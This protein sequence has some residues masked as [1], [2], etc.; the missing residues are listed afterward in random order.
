MTRPK[1]AVFA[2]PNATILNT[3]PLVTSNLARREHQL[4]LRTNR[5][6][7]AARFDALR[8]QRLAA[9]VTV[10]IEQFSAHPL[11][12]DAAQLYAPPDGYLDSS[13]AFHEERESPSDKAVYRVTLGP[14]DGL[15]PLPYMARQASGQPWE[16][17]GV[18]PFAAP[19][20]NRQ[21][22]FPDASRLF[23]EIDR[24]AIGHDGLVN[25]LSSQA[26][27]DFYRCAPPG[28]YTCGLPAA[29]RTDMGQGEISEEIAGQDF[30]PYRPFHLLR[31][32]ARGSLA[33]AANL[34]QRVLDSGDYLAALWLEGSP[35]IEETVFWLGLTV[36]TDLPIVGCASQRP[37]GSI[38]NDGD[39]NIVDAVQYIV[40]RDWSD[41]AGMDRV[42]AVLVQDKRVYA[43]REAQKV[44]A[45]PGGYV[46]VGGAGGI[47]AIMGDPGPPTLLFV[48]TRRRGRTSEV[49]LRTLSDTTAG[50]RRST[51]GRV[52]TILVQVKEGP[53]RLMSSALPRVSIIKASHCQP[54]DCSGSADD[55]AGVLAEIERNLDV[56]P[57]AGFVGEGMAPYGF[58]NQ[59]LD[60]ALRRAVFSGMPV[61]NVGRGN[62]EGFA[63]TR[64]PFIAGSN[65][66]ATK[67]RLLLMACLLKFGALPAAT[68]PAQ[69]T[70]DEFSQTM[71]HVAGYQ[72]VFDS[73]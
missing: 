34:V 55:A 14:E 65:L 59:S 29:E 35:T 15:Y 6:G 1:I 54:D 51:T 58:M 32:P 17:D 47:V 20:L 44:D 52:E 27:F 24:F 50:V 2:G 43:A 62:T 70:G 28:G 8:P 68:D 53:D 72:S 64:P 46:A 5:D 26:E 42:G 56:A 41:A 49:R 31:Q 40:S 22:F 3:E 21:P 16:D 69:P 36:D 7:T 39:R 38:G 25:P 45:R 30:Y 61:V 73:H 9:P 12:R 19:E 18:Q 57:L 67:A 11:E 33:D 63:V 10:Y 60:S 23:E 4:A 48:P 71:Q 66:T 37:H 13:G